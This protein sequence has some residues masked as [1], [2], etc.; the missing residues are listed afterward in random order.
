MNKDDDKEALEKRFK[1]DM[2]VDEALARFARATEEELAVAAGEPAADVLAEGS[3]ALVPFKGT[4]IRKV[5]RE[6]EWW[7]S[8]VDVVEALAGSTNPRRYWSDLK[9][10]MSEKEGFSELYDQIVQLPMP[11]ADG[12]MY[13]TD[14]VNPETLFRI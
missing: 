1:L 7:F 8:V 13:R 6:G 5:F 10:Q 3:V 9:R 11:G 14:A 4:Q 2:P 12:K